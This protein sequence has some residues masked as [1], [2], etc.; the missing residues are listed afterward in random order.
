MGNSDV[1]SPDTDELSSDETPLSQDYPNGLEKATECEGSIHHRKQ[2][3]EDDEKKL[4]L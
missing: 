3:Q 4:C 2:H 1:S